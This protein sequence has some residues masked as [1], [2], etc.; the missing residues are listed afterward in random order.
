LSAALRGVRAP[1]GSGL[2][3]QQLGT[4]CFLAAEAMFF[5]G[6]V[7]VAL[8][9]RRGSAAWPPA[10][11]VQPDLS[12]P[13]A[14]TLVLLASSLTVHLA[15]QAIRR[16]D[17]RRLTQWIGVTSM[18]G[19]GFLAGQ[20]TEFARLGGWQPG[21]GS[22]RALFD[23]VVVL[24][25]AHVIGGICLLLFVFAGAIA[26]RFSRAEHTAVSG[27][28]LYWHFVT[29]AWLL[30]LASV[31]NLAPLPDLIRSAGVSAF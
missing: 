23:S 14:N 27:T 2:S 1:T 13:L 11:T 25:G 24:H 10:G 22:Y 19:V 21:N 30:M 20:I 29:A 12:L 9:V 31:V 17:T 4:L 8:E 26:G 28:E 16:G 3:N 6:L 7:F 15:V 5:L 18:L